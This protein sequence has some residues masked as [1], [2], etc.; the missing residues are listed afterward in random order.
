MISDSGAPQAEEFLSGK[1]AHVDVAG[2]EKELRKLW[3]QAAH[4]EDPDSGAGTV[5]RA[6]SLNLILISSDD[7]AEQ[8]CS[9]ILDEIEQGH[10][11]R[12]I[13]A[14][15]RPQKAHRLDAWVSARCHLLGSSKQIC[16][17]Q[18]TVCCDGGKPQE[19]SSVVRPLIL[20][21]LPVFIWWR[22]PR[23]N[24]SEFSVLHTCARR[25]VVDSTRYAFEHRLLI[26][27]AQLIASN[28]HCLY[29]SDMTWRRLHAWCR[30]TAY[31]FDGFP[32]PVDALSQVK[33]VRIEFAGEGDSVSNV[34][35]L[36]TGWLAS[37]LGWQPVALTSSGAK[38][39]SNGR[40]V[41]VIFAACR[42]TD[43]ASGLLK[44]LRVSFEN[45]RRELQIE[46]EQTSEAE[47]VVARADNSDEKEATR[48]AQHLNE[49]DLIGQELEHLGPDP[50]YEESANMAALLL[51]LR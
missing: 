40:D 46:L 38:F 6:C 25:F 42:G 50:I 12:S 49:V 5:V 29:V 21:D 41:E 10:P 33:Q 11:C 24:W 27:T 39:K 26:D 35:L 15:F 1:L 7:D 19:L 47:F 3:K 32:M 14:I 43:S 2:I 13:L 23:L 22:Q 44:R 17:E 31:S 9:D 37:R 51:T 8:A 20:P 30:A 16:S 18:I 48:I 28:Q 4:G 36:F 45:D 34:A